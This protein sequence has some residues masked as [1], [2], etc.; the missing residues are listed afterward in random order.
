MYLLCNILLYLQVLL[1][2]AEDDLEKGIDNRSGPFVLYNCARLATLLQSFQDRVAQ[3]EAG[4]LR[5]L[6]NLLMNKNCENEKKTT[7]QQTTAYFLTI[8]CKVI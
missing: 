1:D 7:S 3:G 5:H 2:L 6:H 4:V 8:E